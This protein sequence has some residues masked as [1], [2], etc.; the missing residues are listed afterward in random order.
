LKVSNS[1]PPSDLDP[2]QDYIISFKVCNGSVESESET[3][4]VSTSSDGPNMNMYLIIIAC[5]GGLVFLILVVVIG[6]CCNR[7]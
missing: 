4:Y 5:L 7:R 6:V 1:I 3:F 2:A